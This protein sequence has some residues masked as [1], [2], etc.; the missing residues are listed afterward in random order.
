MSMADFASFDTEFMEQLK[1]D[2]LVF[3]SEI[4]ALGKKHGLSEAQVMRIILQAELSGVGFRAEA[5]VY[6]EPKADE[7]SEVPDERK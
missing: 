4:V 5:F 6:A 3:V 2:R 7:R 1:H